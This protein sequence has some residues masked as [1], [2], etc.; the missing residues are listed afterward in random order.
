MDF[1]KFTLAGFDACCGEIDALKAGQEDAT[2]A[3]NPIRMGELGI[4]TAAAIVAK[5]NA[6]TFK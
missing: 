2:A 4:L 5:E 6:D 1:A 3:Q